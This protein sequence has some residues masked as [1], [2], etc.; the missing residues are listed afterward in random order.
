MTNVPN[1][2]D[3]LSRALVGFDRMFEEIE[4]RFANSVNTNYPPHNILKTGD[5][6]Y[7]IQLAVTGFDKS[8]IT[9]TLEDNVLVIKGMGPVSTQNLQSVYLYRGLATR[10]FV[11]EFPLAEHLKVVGA[12]IKNGLLSVKLI[13]EFPEPPK[14]DVKV[15][16]I[17]EGR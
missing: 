17:V 16:D 15:I 8:D 6:Q 9:V 3:T 14:P 4:R 7:E 1:K 2:F 12:E 5:H 13:R 11:R 10:D